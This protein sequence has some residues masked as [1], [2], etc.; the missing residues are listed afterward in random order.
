[1]RAVAAVIGMA[2]LGCRTAGPAASEGKEPM[3]TKVKSGYPQVYATIGELKK[4][5]LG[6]AAGRPATP[7]GARHRGR[8]R[9]AG[10]PRAE[11]RPV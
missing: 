9:P 2:L 10:R 1:M 4:L 6:A 5:D 8:G 3:T 11:T 7:P